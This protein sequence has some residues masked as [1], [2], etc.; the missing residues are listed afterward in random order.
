MTKLRDAILCSEDSSALTTL[1][2]NAKIGNLPITVE[3]IISSQNE[4]DFL[5][6]TSNCGVRC[7]K[8]N[9]ESYKDKRK[10]DTDI[11]DELMESDIQVLIMIGWEYGYIYEKAIKHYGNR[12]IGIVSPLLN[13]QYER[14][15]HLASSLHKN[16]TWTE[17]YFH[18]GKQNRRDQ[19]IF[20]N[21]QIPILREDTIESLTSRVESNENIA[22]PAGILAAYQNYW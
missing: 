20:L 18:L 14:D 22:I 17:V 6:L 15:Y 21:L 1:I 5:N 2:E 13:F 9:T 7:C 3:L 16:Q 10:F 19:Q 11:Y 12:M 4:A 8:Y